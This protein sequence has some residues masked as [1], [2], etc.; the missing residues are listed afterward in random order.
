M[1]GHAVISL[2][3][4]ALD[5]GIVAPVAPE[6]KVNIQCPCGTVSVVVEYSN[7][8]SGRARFQSVPAFIFAQDLQVELTGYGV[9]RY[10]IAYGGAFY[11]IA[12][13][14]QFGLDLKTASFESLRSAGAACSE[15]VKKQVVLEHPVSEDLAFLYGTVLID[16]NNS[17]PEGESSNFC[18]FADAQVSA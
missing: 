8:R 1:C 6:T 3:R 13:G 17:S 7:G 4:Y 16:D 2:G 10:D 15:A 5:Y 18:V 9:I 12:T 14:N 11:A